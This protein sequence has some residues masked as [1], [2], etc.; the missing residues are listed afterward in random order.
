LSESL[1]Y[2]DIRVGKQ[3]GQTKLPRHAG[4]FFK[5]SAAAMA[6]LAPESKIS[7]TKKAYI[8]TVPII[9]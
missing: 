1:T 7:N 9:N 2:Y 5:P 3:A 6:F 4:S 8:Q